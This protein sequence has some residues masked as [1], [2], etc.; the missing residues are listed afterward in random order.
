MGSTFQFN[1][2]FCIGSTLQERL[3]ISIMVFIVVI[4]GNKQSWFI[5]K[6]AFVLYYF[7]QTV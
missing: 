7:V 6:G 3:I 4:H 2:A 1:S 5:H